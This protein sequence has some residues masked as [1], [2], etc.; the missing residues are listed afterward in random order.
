MNYNIRA[1]DEFGELS[2]EERECYRE[3]AEGLEARVAELTES[4]EGRTGWEF[5]MHPL[6]EEAM[7]FGGEIY[8]YGVGL[9]G[10]RGR[11]EAG[12]HIMLAGAKLSS[13][14]HIAENWPPAWELRD[15]AN[16][17]LSEAQAMLSKAREAL[18]ERSE[19]GIGVDLFG[20]RGEALMK[21]VS[22]LMDQVRS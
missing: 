15:Y 5:E 19:V 6:V 2:L 11:L 9:E 12:M 3:W 14:L 8:G 10:R 21:A 7:A 4:H 1:E 13:I 22:A 20:E 18:I 17:Q 16:R